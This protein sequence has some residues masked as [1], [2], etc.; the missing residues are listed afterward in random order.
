METLGEALQN[1]DYS[2]T[3]FYNKSDGAY[4]PDHWVCSLG[5]NNNHARNI[6]RDIA[7]AVLPKKLHIK[8]AP[9]EGTIFYTIPGGGSGGGRVKNLK[10]DKPATHT[11]YWKSHE[12]HEIDFLHGV[13]QPFTT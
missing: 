9:D 10:D 7:N 2:S 1:L 3:W 5:G 13:E 8:H 4:R 12:K 6:M 11:E